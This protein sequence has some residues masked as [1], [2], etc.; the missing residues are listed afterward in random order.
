[1][2]LST[3]TVLDPNPAPLSLSRSLSLSLSLSL[4]D[5]APVRKSYK[6]VKFITLYNARDSDYRETDIAYS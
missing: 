4:I 6:K 2:Y 5:C 1:M 3:S